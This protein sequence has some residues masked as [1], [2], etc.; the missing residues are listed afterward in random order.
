[1]KGLKSILWIAGVVCLL[2]VL[3]LVLP[4]ST[5]DQM[6]QVLGGVSLPEG[7]LVIYG[8]R[9]ISATFMAIGVFYIMLARDPG[10]YGPMVPFSGAAAVFLGITCG[11]T[12]I[13]LGLSVLVYLGDS[14]G[15]IIM[16][17]LILVFWN[18]SR[19]ETETSGAS[20]QQQQQ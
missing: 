2:A 19:R 6:T 17:I 9:A 5:L 8:V 3:G 4:M 10:R 13:A 20:E 18:K 16:G 11:V 1:M 12:G 7:P 15:C 14:A